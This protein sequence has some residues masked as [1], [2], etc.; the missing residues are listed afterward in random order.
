MYEN[1]KREVPVVLTVTL[2]KVS[3]DDNFIVF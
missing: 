2:I 3:N 1:L